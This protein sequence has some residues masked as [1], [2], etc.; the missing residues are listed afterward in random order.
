MMSL[1][2]YDKK[3]TYFLEKERQI[4]YFLSLGHR[5]GGQSEAYPFVTLFFVS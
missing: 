3:S 1:M 5:S 2:A 4:N